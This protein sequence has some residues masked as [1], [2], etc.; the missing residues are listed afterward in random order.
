[1]RQ[2]SRGDPAGRPFYGR[3]LESLRHQENINL[4]LPGCINFLHLVNSEA[5]D[6]D[7]VDEVFD[8][9]QGKLAPLAGFQV[10][11]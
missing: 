4:W 3:R 5:Q 2:K 8:F 1:M 7:H 9:I 6:L 10:F 11:V